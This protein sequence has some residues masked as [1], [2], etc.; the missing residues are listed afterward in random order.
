MATIQIK[1]Y[2]LKEDSKMSIK[3]LERA[4][5]IRRFSIENDSNGLYK[6]LIDKLMQHFKNE[7]AH[8]REIKAYY[9]DN[10]EDF[11]GFSSDSEIQFAIDLQNRLKKSTEESI[12][13]AFKV[14]I[15]RRKISAESFLP[16]SKLFSEELVDQAIPKEE[17]KKEGKTHE[18]KHKKKIC[19]NLVQNFKSSL[20]A[21]K[22]SPE[23]LKQYKEHIK[24]HLG[25]LG[26]EVDIDDII[27]DLVTKDDHYQ[28]NQ[29]DISN[30][31]SVISNDPNSQT[32]TVTTFDKDGN[33][34]TT[35]TS[36][37]STS[38][39]SSTINSNPIPS[40]ASISETPETSISNLQEDDGFNMVDIE[41]EVKIMNAVQSLKSMGFDDENN[42]LTS[43]VTAKDGKINDVLDALSNPLSS[44]N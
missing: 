10:E 7:I 31:T 2:L 36:S 29:K 44:K 5:E 27:D 9:L 17:T 15:I 8:R 14:Y 19:Q 16:A 41:K 22:N 33:K 32:S 18:P 38:T 11:V 34:I 40:A 43:L 30:E 6:N 23:G 24:S 28:I 42:W 20:V 39:S 3:G 4:T 21:L 26:M 1:A 25:P 12:A 37:S 35:T 13:N